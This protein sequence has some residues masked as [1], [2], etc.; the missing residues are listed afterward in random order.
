MKVREM[1]NR[2]GAGGAG[3]EGREAERPGLRLRFPAGRRAV[4]QAWR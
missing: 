1:P 3:G 4:P 2:V